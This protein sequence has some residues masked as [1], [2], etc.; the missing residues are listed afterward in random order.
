VYTSDFIR[1]G[2][3]GLD[4]IH[5]NDLGYALLANELIGAVNS[6]F[7]CVI[8][9]VNPSQYASPNASR[10]RPATDRWYPISVENL[11]QG[12]DLLFPYRR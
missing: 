12:L 9:S 1:G 3:F 5:P 10:A 7:G 2:L 8:P 11:Q 6:K 4:G